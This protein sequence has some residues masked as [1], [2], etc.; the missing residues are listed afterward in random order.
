MSGADTLGAGL[1]A[2]VVA[3]GVGALV[4]RV[5]SP[6]AVP[7]R[8]TVSLIIGIAIIDLCVALVLF[9]GGGVQALRALSGCLIGLGC[10]GFLQFR[11][12]L[13]IAPFLK[14]DSQRDYWF[15]AIIAIVAVV[16]L[17]IAVAPSSKIDE[18]HYHMLLPK[19]VIEDN[20]LHLYREPYES[21]IFPQ[22]GFQLGLSVLHSVS[23]PE[24]GN[25]LSWGLGVALVVLI[26][27]VVADLT[28][29]STA[30]W[31]T[32]AIAAV[33][34]YPSVWHVTSGPHALGDLTTLT[35]CLLVLVPE[36]RVGQLRPEK[37]LLLICL[38]ACLAA[39]TKISIL[40]LA[41][42]LTAIG[43]HKGVAHIGLKKALLIAFSVWATFYGPMLAWTTIQCGSPFGL[44]TAQLLHSE[45]FAPETV[46]QLEAAR[47]ANQNGWLPLLRTLGPS[48]SVGVVAAFG[49]IGYAAFARGRVFRVLFGLVVGQSLL[50]AWLLP[51]D[52][53][54]LGGVQYAV[55]VM[56]AWVF[57]P[58]RAGVFLITR[59]WF[60]L[61]VLCL[62]WLAVQAYYARP[63]VEVAS[64]VM[65]RDSFLR[66]YVAFTNDF[67]SLD[68]VLPRDAVIYV[69]NSRLPS[70]YAPRPVIL[71]LE[72][73]R[74]RGPVYRF[75][76]RQDADSEQKS[77]LCM[78]K[79]YEDGDATAV[80]FR[81]PG[82]QL[83]YDELIVERC[84][85]VSSK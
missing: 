57:W 26:S 58:S 33:G 35:A 52:F 28:K 84:A 65:S 22:M 64:G 43:V 62:P 38:S 2:L 51:H 44:A 75:S 18:L 67:Q 46:A 59:W 20:G 56:G 45:F 77:L 5:S 24:A 30:G 60:V 71:T 61:A 54:F 69:V 1:L 31:M 48:V 79:I 78:E 13:S 21:A 16:N 8:L 72:D 6:L 42:C 39:M 74:S 63:F 11:K 34:L 80:A 81:T 83:F 29:N 70:F 73:L 3:I 82:R 50:I 37:R 19:R 10:F 76:E 14:V 23:F 12:Y 7:W 36:E 85:A 55:L 9:L 40:P 53:R 47:I 32:G 66:D 17:I 68:R 41:L 4:V 25:V 15:I 49:V 27:G